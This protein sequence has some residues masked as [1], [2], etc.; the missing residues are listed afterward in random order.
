LHRNTGTST[1]A[2][3]RDSGRGEQGKGRLSRLDASNAD[4]ADQNETPLLEIQTNERERETA[5]SGRLKPTEKA[6]E[7]EGETVTT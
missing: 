4:D 1:A 3:N 6:K 5:K 7:E 2:K